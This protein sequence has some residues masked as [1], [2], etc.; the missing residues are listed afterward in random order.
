L[1]FSGS[2]IPLHFIQLQ[3]AIDGCQV[4]FLFSSRQWIFFREPAQDF[5]NT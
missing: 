3:E 2:F 1:R 5:S 4:F